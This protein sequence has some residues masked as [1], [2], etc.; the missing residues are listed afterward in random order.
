MSP[1]GRPFLHS[2]RDV[3]TPV[4]PQSRRGQRVRFEL[5]ILGPTIVKEHGVVVALRPREL[6]VLAALALHHPH[7]VSIDA[8]ADV[9]WATPPATVTKSVQMHISRV[10]SALG[11]DAIVTEGTAYRL[12]PEWELDADRLEDHLA[13]A[14]RSTRAGDHAMSR[15]LLEAARTEVRGVPFATLPATAETMGERARREQQLLSADEDLVLAYLSTQDAPA[16]VALAAALVEA[17]PYRENR[18][19]ML[20]VGQYRNGQRRES[21]RTLRRGRDVVL[22]MAGLATSVAS[23]RLESW[24]L[25][26]DPVLERL[27]PAHLVGHGDPTDSADLQ[28]LFIGRSELLDSCVHRLRQVVDSNE[29]RAFVVSGEEGVGKSAFVAQLAVRAALEGWSVVWGTCRPNP[30]LA[31]EPLGDIARQV[32][33]GEAHA[34]DVFDSSLVADLAIL[35]DNSSRPAVGD[36]GEVIAEV[37]ALHAER[38]PTLIV[39]DDA[40]HLSTTVRRILEHLGELPG[41]VAVMLVADTDPADGTGRSS[42]ADA[43]RIALLG[44]DA[45]E[46]GRLL[47]ALS[48]GSIS[49][50]VAASACAA[51]GG[52][53]L[54]LRELAGALV[55]LPAVG[56]DR[57]LTVS[58]SVTAIAERALQRSS[59][60]V[61]L[62]ASLLAVAGSS[63]SPT[64]IGEVVSDLEGRLPAD[65]RDAAIMEGI[66]SG[67]FRTDPYSGI[68]LA[69]DGLRGAVLAAMPP[70]RQVHIHELLGLALTASGAGPLAVAP[71]LVAASSRDVERA[72]NAATEAGDAARAATMFVEAAEYFAQAAWLADQAL[73]DERRL[74]LQLRR[75]ECLRLASDNA[76]H[77]LAW[78]V[79]RE[80]Q[81]AGHADVMCLAATALCRLGP[82]TLAGRLDVD[83]AALVER[84]LDECTDRALRISC[85]SR[86]SLFYSMS[87]DVGRS[88]AHFIDALDMARTDPDDVLRANVL[89]DAYIALTHP[90][91]WPLRRELAGEL[92]ALAELL[93]SDQYRFEALHLYYSVHVQFPDPLLR[94]TFHR[95]VQLVARLRSSAHRW[96]LGYQ[97]ACLAYLDGRLEEALSIS[98]AAQAQSHVSASRSDGNHAI[99]LFAVRLAQARGQELVAAMDSMITD[100][101]GLPGWRAVAAWLAALRGDRARVLVECD[102]LDSGMALPPDTAWSGAAMLLGRAI[103]AFGTPQQVAIIE[104]ILQPMTGLMTWVGSCTVGSFDVALAEL[105]LARN[106]LDAA[107]HHLEIARR[108]TTLLGARVY[109]ADLDDIADRVLASLG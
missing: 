8:I 102:A 24:I 14:R 80:A 76:G 81:Q 3:N 61:R 23:A 15:V 50:E 83:L 10:R 96:M 73:G 52:N 99:L 12:G 22:E 103:A 20:A 27:S 25:A 58:A 42:F 6:D 106:D 93:D 4:V 95:Q 64:V 85:A 11:A 53:P 19:M 59:N 69:S 92:L 88:R 86:A 55:S 75:A 36:I 63:T 44:L 5:A 34:L 105:A 104:S 68:D 100:Q 33:D 48:D 74:L 47:D 62:V 54:L 87:G 9:L 32:L 56:D 94:T 17:E 16:A 26:D 82:G 66:R 90:D 71:H 2:L 72:I 30:S 37:V 65:A 1:V 98:T 79:A 77:E 28:Q 21:L 13:R 67:L 45:A 40:Q 41:R 89:S 101:P 38:T 39:V 7:P 51:T 78:Q 35:W 46:T 97:A 18:W 57:E 43:D 107:R 91:D 60:A 70:G 49:A 84:S 29:A 108:S 109:Q 31:L